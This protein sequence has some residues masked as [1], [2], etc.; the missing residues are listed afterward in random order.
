MMWA[1]DFDQAEAAKNADLDPKLGGILCLPTP[2]RR[3]SSLRAMGKFRRQSVKK[4]SELD[5]PIIT[6]CVAAL[7]LKSRNKYLT[8]FGF[9]QVTTVRVSRVFGLTCF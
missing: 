9:D 5:G 2:I 7:I 4:Q 6:F 3:D 8:L 1:F